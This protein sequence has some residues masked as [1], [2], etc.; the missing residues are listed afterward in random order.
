MHELI[1]S[2]E[3][4]LICDFGH[5]KIH[6]NHP[7]YLE[8]FEIQMKILQRDGSHGNRKHNQF[9]IRSIYSRKGFESGFLIFRR[10]HSA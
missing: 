10:Q 5:V 6:K 2:R 4:S 3:I 7:S 1:Q 9:G 8:S